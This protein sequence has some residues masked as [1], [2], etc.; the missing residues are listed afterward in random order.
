MAIPVTSI[1]VLTGE[2]AERFIEQCD[3]NAREMR[4]TLWSQ[5]RETRFKAFME[6]N[7]RRLA[8]VK[9]RHNG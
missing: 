6:R 2:V 4:G 9:L 7:N 1:P 3:R 5:E 8:E